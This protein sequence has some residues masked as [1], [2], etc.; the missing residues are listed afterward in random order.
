M[1]ITKEW[2]SHPGWLENLDHLL[3]PEY[4]LQETGLVRCRGLGRLPLGRPAHR[5]RLAARHRTS[6][7]SA[8]KSSCY[9]WA[10][11]KICADRLWKDGEMMVLSRSVACERWSSEV[12]IAV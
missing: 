12:F 4:L 8:E 5:R 3:A 10:F 7:R 2:S 9:Y 6:A 11:E 1:K